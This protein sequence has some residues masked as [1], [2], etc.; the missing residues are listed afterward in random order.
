VV[1]ARAKFLDDI[2]DRR[3]LSGGLLTLA[4]YLLPLV[5]LLLLFVAAGAARLASRVAA[6][7]NTG[8]RI[9]FAAVLALPV[10]G[11][12]I[13]SPLVP[14][15]RH[16]NAQA[17][18]SLYYYDFRPEKNP[19]IPYKAAI[20]LSP[21]WADL[22]AR[23]PPDSVRIAAAPFYFESNDWDAPRWERLAHQRVLPG[24]LTGLCVDRRPGEL[25]SDARFRF[26]NAV[27]LADDAELARRH[28][29]YVVWQK[30]YVQTSKGAPEA[31]GAN[32]AN[33]ETALRAKFGAPVFEDSALI[34]F[35]VGGAQPAAT[36]RAR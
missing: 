8:T 18:N 9:G 33:C 32:T 34:A 1:A 25:P 16:P 4:R 30:P 21:F 6:L 31:K 3:A 29:D 15:L 7:V 20:P 11:L 28:I 14:M 24:S 12:A 35:R 10:L 5:P 27:H 26:R 36:A 22:G 19:L 2:A 23:L 17:L 13:D